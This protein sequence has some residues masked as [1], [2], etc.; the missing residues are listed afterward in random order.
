MKYSYPIALLGLL[1]LACNPLTPEEKPSLPQDEAR[2]AQW[3]TTARNNT[4]LSREAR[5]TLLQHAHTRAKNLPGD[6]LKLQFLS[7]IAWAYYKSFEDSLTFRTL[8]RQVLEATP[9]PTRYSA[10]GKAYWHLA[11]FFEE[12]GVLDS[13]FYHYKNALKS[14]K[15]LPAD[16]TT[17]SQMGRKLYSM[18]K[19]QGIYK[20]YLGADGS[21]AEAITHFRKAR[22][23]R[24][25]HECYNMWGIIA[26][27]LNEWDR[28]L[29]HYT[30]AK[31]YLEQADFPNKEAKRWQLQNNIAYTYIMKKEYSQ[32][33]SL[34]TPLLNNKQLRKEDPKSYATILASQAYTCFKGNYHT[35]EAR[36]LLTQALQINDSLGFWYD[37]PRVQQYYA[38]VMAARGDTLTALQYAQAARTLAKKTANNYRL[39]EVLQLLTRLHP[40]KAAP[41]AEA[42]YTLNENIQ[43]EEHIQ[44]DK[45][46]RL[47]LET[48]D[49]IAR[50]KV[51]AQQKKIQGMLV[52][53]L[54]GF[55]VV[56]GV[57]TFIFVRH[58]NRVHHRKQKKSSEEIYTLMMDQHVKL[59]EGKNIEKKRISEEL[60]DSVLGKMLGIRLILMALNGK[61]DKASVEEREKMLE[62]LQQLEVSIRNL[63]HDLH[64]EA[65]EEFQDF[66]AAI[67]DLLG[68]ARQAFRVSCMFTY[69]RS[70]DWNS[71]PGV[72]KMHLY[73]ILQEAMKN[74]IS[75]GQCSAIDID[76]TAEND[77][78]KLTIADNGK[79]FDL[80]QRKDG[81]GLQNMTSRVEK[82]AA[83]LYI[84]SAKNKGTTIKVVAPDM[85]VEQQKALVY[86]VKE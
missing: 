29:R 53:G 46:A 4:R 38:E 50:N 63:S 9:T 12:Q 84:S 44:R 2:L 15:H 49:V 52:T 28:A 62:S 71:L 54:G 43:K 69:N 48:D 56:S 30:E 39:L 33:R 14:Y 32:A 10:L 55:I 73:R 17:H 75:H 81:I 85:Y 21:I 19:I 68:T 79:G 82:I 70:A 45:F 47:R 51:L 65:Y 42:Y 22:D 5:L 83:K 24:W 66:I 23:N 6:S 41:Y 40:A 37:Q 86:P 80:K 1:L 7:D 74:G 20:D 18:G 57:F 72:I 60:H 31:H 67:E 59:E 35:D 61:G 3:I 27:G 78:I 13:A 11:F 58:R 8:N 36:A 16:S 64:D 76:L 25:L 77:S 34:Y 26:D